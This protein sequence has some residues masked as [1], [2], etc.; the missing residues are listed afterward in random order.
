MI[1]RKTFVKI[2]TESIFETRTDIAIA[3]QVSGYKKFHKELRDNRYLKKSRKIGKQKM[4]TEGYSIFFQYALVK[5][6]KLG[7]CDEL[8]QYLSI[9][10]VKKLA[11]LNAAANVDIH[12]SKE[13]PHVYL[14]ISIQ[15]K[16][17]NAP[18]RWEVDA[19]DPRIIDI[20]KRPD[21]SIKNLELLEYGT[22]PGTMSSFTVHDYISRPKISFLFDI[23]KP[24]E[25]SS[26]GN[27]TPDHVIAEREHMYNDYTLED[28]YRHKMLDDEG[29][30]RYPQ[31]AST[32]QKSS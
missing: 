2:C 5:H 6:T 3:N 12:F 23:P 27:M 13:V 11:L 32:W 17:E 14:N 18:S 28:A 8:A 20:S 31:K 24:V 7:N 30:I 19:W 22:E 9:K 10:I 25:G 29:E 26:N 4:R 21:G 16:D 15:L 1:D